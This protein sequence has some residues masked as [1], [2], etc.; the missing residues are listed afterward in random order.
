MFAIKLNLLYR[1]ISGMEKSKRE[2]NEET[3][4]ASTER[5]DQIDEKSIDKETDALTKSLVD[6]K[7]R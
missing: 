6:I 5:N 3:S 4:S 2:R 7:S 1:E